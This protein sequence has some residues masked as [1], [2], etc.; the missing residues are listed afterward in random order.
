MARELPP[1]PNLEHLKSQAKDLVDAHRRGEPEAFARIRAAVPAF[2]HRSDADIARSPFALHDAQS[3]IAR[4]YGCVSWAELRT[5]VGAAAPEPS[6]GEAIAVAQA[7]AAMRLPPG[8]EAEVRAAI[9]QRTTEAG[10]TPSRLPVLPVRNAVV[11][12][13]AMIPLDISRACSIRAIDAATASDRFVAVFAQKVREVDE[14][15]LDD[16]HPNGSLCS[17][18]VVHRRGDGA[19]ATT[20]ASAPGSPVFW[21]LVEGIRWITLEALEQTDPYYVA[22]VTDAAMDHGD[23]GQIAAL[24]RQLR[25][26]A[27]RYADT[28]SIKTEVNAAIDRMTEPRQLADLV[29]AN[30]PIPVAEMAAYAAETELTRKLDRAIA[31]LG[32]ELAK[33]LA[34]P[35]PPQ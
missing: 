9:E 35:A 30:F 20:T 6:A 18:R 1:K 17:L 25:V 4:E 2:A 3:A 26:L 34:P 23:D 27:H 33:V 11:F 8:V 10:P 16:L 7:L 14:P 15:G 32:V 13:G 12:P 28:M 31:L 22:R 5:K 29:M 21:T 24:D 19:T